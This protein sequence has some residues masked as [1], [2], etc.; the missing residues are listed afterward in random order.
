MFCDYGD[1]YYYRTKDA[2]LK[3]G[4]KVIVPAGS[5]NVRRR[6]Q[7]ADIEYFTDADLPMP[8]DQIKFILEKVEDEKDGPP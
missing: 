4:D 3:I 5:K 7:I 8:L 1:T 2:S 6:V